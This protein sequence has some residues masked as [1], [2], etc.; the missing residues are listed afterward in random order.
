M[1]TQENILYVGESFTPF[2]L[3]GDAMDVLISAV[4]DFGYVYEGE[5]FVW[6]WVV[7]GGGGARWMRNPNSSPLASPFFGLSNFTCVNVFCTFLLNWVFIMLCAWNKSMNY[8]F[9]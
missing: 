9:L 3:V 4:K 6:W 5:S 1:Q 7:E 2:T 8:Y